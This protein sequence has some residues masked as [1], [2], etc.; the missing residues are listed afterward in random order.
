MEHHGLAA[1]LK[2]VFPLADFFVQ[3][4]DGF[5]SGKVFWPPPRVHGIKS[6]IEKYAT[7]FLAALDPGRRQPKPDFVLGIDDLEL[8]NL[9][10][11]ENVIQ[12]FRLA[13]AAEIE[14]RRS[15]MNSHTFD[16]F[17]ARVK[18]KCS[19]HLFVPM[20]EAYFYA[21][22]AALSAAGCARTPILS[23]DCDVEHFETVDPAYL[24]THA[25]PMHLHPKRYLQFLL[26]PASYRETEQGVSA[27]LAIDWRGVLARA[28]QTLFLRSMFQDLAHA[29]EL[30]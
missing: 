16:R 18:D 7:A 11:P 10:G 4:V 5:T 15:A 19:F 21:D 13:V 24:A 1:S 22:A 8:E 20:A 27:L 3:R 30:D 14:D 28:Q 2:R 6:A 17:V 23:T 12:A 29:L 25:R 9:E 26:E